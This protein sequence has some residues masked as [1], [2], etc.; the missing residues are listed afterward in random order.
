MVPQP[1]AG[2]RSQTWFRRTNHL[3]DACHN[4]HLQDEEVG[5][6]IVVD[7]GQSKG[8]VVLV[9]LLSATMTGVGGWVGDL[10]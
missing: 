1:A 4:Y 2:G 9:L 10:P 8:V 7:R 5:K 6:T 3:V